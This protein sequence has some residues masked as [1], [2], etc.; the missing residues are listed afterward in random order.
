MHHTIRSF[1][2]FNVYAI[3]FIS[4]IVD[5]VLIHNEVA[6]GERETFIGTINQLLEKHHEPEKGEEG[7]STNPCSNPTSDSDPIA[8]TI[9][10]QGESILKSCLASDF[11]FPRNKRKRAERRAGSGG[12]SK[13]GSGEP[14]SQ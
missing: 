2:R 11:Q 7:E 5:N 3:F 4:Q 6:Q 10:T 1:N 8:K 12:W 9:V 14:D 13:K